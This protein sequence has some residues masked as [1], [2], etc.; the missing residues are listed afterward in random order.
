MHDA[1][2]H[3]IIAN[4][5]YNVF[6]LLKEL[7]QR[8][9]KGTMLAHYTSVEVVEKILKDHEIWMSHPF[10]M[11]DIEE[12]QFGLNLGARMFRDYCYD[13]K[14][15]TSVSDQIFKEFHGFLKYMN[16]KT[17]I[18][19]YV[20]CF[21]AHALGDT[22]G[23]LPM[24]RSYGDYGHGAAIVFDPTQFPQEPVIPLRTAKV[25][26]KS[27]PEREELLNSILSF[28]RDTTIKYYANINFREDEQSDLFMAAFFALFSIKIFA[29][30]TKHPG[31]SYEDEWRIVYLPE[32]DN[33]EHFKEFLS[34][35]IGP[36]GIEPKLKFN[37]KK[38]NNLVSK[39]KIGT[40]QI[41]FH[42][43]VNSVILGPSISSPLA[44]ASFL[45]ALNG[46]DFHKLTDKVHSSSIPLRPSR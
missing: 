24:W 23:S 15:P 26:Y 36:S 10:H 1:N 45:R 5:Y 34:Y 32:W 19:T 43:I 41:D 44:K 3:A 22:D 8:P 17:I 7:E 28:W 42:E 18:D 14:L 13:S 2:Q 12:L 35:N 20:V 4:E 38:Y 33:Q 31:F 11:N 30:F 37:V 21:K 16:D 27:A 9:P 25:L 39:G 6:A 29:I 40:S 46:S